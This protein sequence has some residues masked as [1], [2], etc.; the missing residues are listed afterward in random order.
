MQK[1]IGLAN[2]PRIKKMKSFQFPKGDQRGL[3]PLSLFDPSLVYIPH[4]GTEFYMNDEI[5]QSKA[6]SGNKRFPQGL[7][8]H[9]SE[10]EEIPK[11][12]EQ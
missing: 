5:I 11:P 4:V 10:D 12:W 7:K 2:R 3:I 9:I 8:L 6:N 1:V